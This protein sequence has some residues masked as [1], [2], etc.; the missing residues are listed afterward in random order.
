MTET[1]NTQ[2]KLLKKLYN[3]KKKKSTKKTSCQT[4]ET[5]K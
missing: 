5:G 3:Y 2:K 4:V 1:D